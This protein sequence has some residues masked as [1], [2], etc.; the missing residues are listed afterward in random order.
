MIEHNPTGEDDMKRTSKVHRIISKRAKEVAA[1]IL[2][3]PEN[4]KKAKVA[5]GSALSQRIKN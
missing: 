2:H 5:R 3:D 4:S 1:R